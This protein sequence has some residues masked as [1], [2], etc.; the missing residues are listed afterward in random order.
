MAWVLSSSQP[1]IKLTDC[2]GNGVQSFPFRHW[3]NGWICQKT[4]QKFMTLSAQSDRCPWSSTGQPQAVLQNLVVSMWK[5]ES[6]LLV[7]CAMEH[8]ASQKIQSFQS[9]WRWRVFGTTGFFDGLISW[10]KFGWKSCGA[11]NLPGSFGVLRNISNFGATIDAEGVRGSA[12]TTR[13][14]GI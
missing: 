9:W 4:R 8:L 12:L 5:H 11:P 1:H 6:L 7:H 14:L 10:L 13:A 3:I 2:S